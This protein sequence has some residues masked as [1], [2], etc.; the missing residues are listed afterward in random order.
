MSFEGDVKPSVVEEKVPATS[1]GSEIR[2]QAT[3]IAM[4]SETVCN[5][6]FLMSSYRM[7]VAFG[8][9]F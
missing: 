5:F 1:V 9:K 6:F 8:E 4:M 7:F 3:D 2:S